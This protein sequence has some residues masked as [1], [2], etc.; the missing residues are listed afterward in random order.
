MQ[1]NNTNTQI[2]HHLFDEAFFETFSLTKHAI[3]LS[4][5]HGGNGTSQGKTFRKNLRGVKGVKGLPELLRPRLGG[6]AA[7]ASPRAPWTGDMLF[8]Q[9]IANG[10][11]FLEIVKKW[12]A[13]LMIDGFLLVISSRILSAEQNFWKLF[14]VSAVFFGCALLQFLIVQRQTSVYKTKNTCVLDFAPLY[15]APCVSL[16][17]LN[18]S[19]NLICL[20]CPC[21]FIKEP[22]E[23]HDT[24]VSS[25]RIAS[26]RMC[27]KME[28]LLPFL[29]LVV[30]D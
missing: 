22:V 25:P 9:N 13:G 14:V 30:Q 19:I 11:G 23:W 7:E 17:S 1:K 27:C 12:G 8:C 3:D 10:G 28:W 18:S 5:F 15:V 4:Q 24:C 29:N 2:T 26:L 21:G 16:N 20:T 6:R